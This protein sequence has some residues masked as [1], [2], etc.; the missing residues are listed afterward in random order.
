MS[1]KPQFERTAMLLG[2][3]AINKLNNARV[4]VFGIGGVGGAAAEAL[5]RGGIGRLDFIDP[6][7]V[8]ESNI[9][10]QLIA[11]HDSVGELKVEVMKKRAL[12]INPD[13]VINTFPLFYLPEN[14]DEFDLSCYDYVIDCIDTVSAKIELAVRCDK[15]GIPLI[16][17][18]GTGNKLDP[19]RFVVT[20]LYKTRVC[21]LARVLRRELK[22]RGVRKLK[23]VYSEEEPLM[24]VIK[25]EEPQT[26]TRRS[27]PGSVPFVP[28]VAGYLLAGEV[29]RTIAER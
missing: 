12:S 22:A 10:R 28:P 2:E 26:G 9:N 1:V 19:S 6:D 16:C 8:N 5:V 17:S 15:L 3:D 7:V 27:T 25:H 11:T 13:A 23:V 20:D 4:A 18:M 29:I 21:P 24:P 14:A